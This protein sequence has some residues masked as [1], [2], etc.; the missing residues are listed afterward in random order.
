ME[1]LSKLQ[2]IDASLF[3]YAYKQGK[4]RPVIPAVKAISHSRDG[5]LLVLIPLLLL[6]IAPPQA[7]DFFT[8]LAAALVIERV[9]Y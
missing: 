5:Y 2:K 8:L 1:I 6:L 3:A 4:Q 9:W 7:D